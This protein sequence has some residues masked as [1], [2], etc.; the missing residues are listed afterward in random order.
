MPIKTYT[1]ISVYPEGGQILYGA[2]AYDITAVSNP[3]A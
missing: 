3:A 1:Y 2:P